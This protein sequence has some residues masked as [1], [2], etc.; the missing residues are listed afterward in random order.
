MGMDYIFAGSA[1][2]PRFN[3]EMKGIVE[4][5]G[6]KM[7][8]ERKPQEECTIIEYFMEKPLKYTMPEGTPETII[9]W[10]NDPYD[11]FTSKETKEIYEFIKTKEDEATEISNQIVSELQCC[12]SSRI[13]WSIS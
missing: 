1:S 8:S 10:V 11:N 5:F 12:V 7:V 13:G 4:L 6:G 3:D 2:Y 9:K